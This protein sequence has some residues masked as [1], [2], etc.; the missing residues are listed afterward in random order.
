MSNQEPLLVDYVRFERAPE[1]VRQLG[2][3]VTALTVTSH[4]CRLLSATWHNLEESHGD[5]SGLV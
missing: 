3:T 2:P 1:P 4:V 5:H